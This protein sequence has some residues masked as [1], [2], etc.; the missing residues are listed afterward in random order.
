MVG[1]LFTRYSRTDVLASLYCIVLLVALF[2]SSCYWAPTPLDIP[3]HALESIYPALATSRPTLDL[4]SLLNA[5]PEPTATTAA[6]TPRVTYSARLERPK[7]CWC[8]PVDIF[9]P[10]NMTQWEQRSSV[11]VFVKQGF[12]DW[13]MDEEAERAESNQDTAPSS[14]GSNKSKKDS[15]QHQGT[16]SSLPESSEQSP[17]PSMSWRTKWNALSSYFSSRSP[18]GRNNPT[19]KSKL[20][21]PPGRLDVKHK[22]A[23]RAP[24]DP[25]PKVGLLTTPTTPT[26]TATPLPTATAT[27]ASPATETASKAEPSL[28][29]WQ[30]Q[31]DLRPYGGAVVVDFRWGRG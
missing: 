16:D 14:K 31:Y 23:V 25:L 29:W 24:V 30:K 6:P 22:P 3:S 17:A 27:E 18:V 12:W 21:G 5:P 9:E 7:R 11:L 19:V 10:F 20:G 15:S 26:P 1:T 2:T 13:L 8:A 4:R 28:R